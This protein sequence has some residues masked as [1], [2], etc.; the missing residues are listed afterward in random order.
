M[1]ADDK[2]LAIDVEMR[3]ALLAPRMELVAIGDPAR[4]ACATLPATTLP[5]MDE[6]QEEAE[7]MRLLVVTASCMTVGLV[8]V[9]GDPAWLSPDLAWISTVAE[10]AREA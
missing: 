4:P 8:V 5:R 1:G 3:T 6:P 7:L 2:H 10:L 9:A